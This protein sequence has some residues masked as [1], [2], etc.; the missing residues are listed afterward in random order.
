MNPW[1]ELKPNLR[2]I[3]MDFII[4]NEKDHIWGKMFGI[5]KKKYSKNVKE[6]LFRF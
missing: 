3:T 6:T 2:P 1:P 5:L 4:E